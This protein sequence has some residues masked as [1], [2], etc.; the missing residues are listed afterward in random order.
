M[1][2]KVEGFKELDAALQEMKKSAAKAVARRALMKAAAPIAADAQSGVQ[3]SSGSTRRSIGV[4]AAL[5]K[6][7]RKQSGGGAKAVAGG[8]FRSEAKDYVEVHIGPR[9]DGSF[10]S[11]PD[12]AGLMEEFGTA[13]QSPEPFMRPAWDGNK[14]SALETIRTELAAEIE[15]TRKRAAAKALKA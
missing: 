12:P 3:V 15:K 8:G 10:A 7:Q 1:R 4:A 6:R 2:V 5:T 13:K 11:A 9:T 14:D